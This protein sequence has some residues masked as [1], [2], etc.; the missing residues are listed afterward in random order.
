LIVSVLAMRLKEDDTGAFPFAAHRSQNLL[1][2]PFN[3]HFAEQREAAMILDPSREVAC[4]ND[5]TGPSGCCSKRRH[6]V[7]NESYRQCNW[8]RF[9]STLFSITRNRSQ[10]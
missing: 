2:V 10:G 7:T 8:P 1:F 5:L 3:I 4:L 6:G 9:K